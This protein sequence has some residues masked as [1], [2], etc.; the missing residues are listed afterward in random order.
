MASDEASHEVI[1][2][3]ILTLCSGDGRTVTVRPLLPVLFVA[4]SEDI[5]QLWRS[6]WEAT[7]TTTLASRPP[8]NFISLSSSTTPSNNNRSTSFSKTQLMQGLR[9]LAAHS[10]QQPSLSVV[11][12]EEATRDALGAALVGKPPLTP[13]STAFE[14]AID[15]VA[16]VVK[17]AG[18]SEE[19][20]WQWPPVELI[21]EED[22]LQGWW[23]SDST[24]TALLSA[25]DRVRLHG[26]NSS[27]NDT[28]PVA[29]HVRVG[30]VL[31]TVKQPLLVLVMPE[32]VR[33]DFCAALTALSSV[34]ETLTSNSL[35]QALLTTTSSNLKRKWRYSPDDVDD[36]GGDDG[37]AVAARVRMRHTLDS[38]KVN[39]AAERQSERQFENELTRAATADG[40]VV[41][42]VTPHAIIEESEDADA[43]EEEQLSNGIATVV[44]S[45]ALQELNAALQAERKASRSLWG[46]VRSM[47]STLL[48]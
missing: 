18:A 34:R 40:V 38:L 47:A 9:W 23:C 39:L 29:L 48:F 13:T 11:T 10:P 30:E 41:V 36:G 16:K 33:F 3:T 15:A 12:L 8:V 7:T 20:R 17:G 44:Q 46:R 19:A 25:L 43:E 22:P 42:G 5:A 6:V 1:Q 26:N 24:Q 2:S 37:G 31:S 14:A 28:S 21:N 4:A 45:R 35:T 32:S 27:D